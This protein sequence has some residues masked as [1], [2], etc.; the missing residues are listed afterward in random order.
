MILQNIEETMVPAERI[1]NPAQQPLM[2]RSHA[3][4]EE[5]D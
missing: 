1:F 5:V 4:G 3:G 2:E